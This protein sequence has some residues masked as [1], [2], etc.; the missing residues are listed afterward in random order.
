MSRFIIDRRKLLRNGVPAGV[1]AALTVACGKITED[2]SAFLL[3][4]SDD[5]E[6]PMKESRTGVLSPETFTVLASLSDYV[7]TNWSLGADMEIY[8]TQLQADLDLKTLIAP[9]YLTE[10]ENAAEL[11][12]RVNRHT[13]NTDE[14][15]ALL[16]FSTFNV[17][18]FSFTKLGRA[19]RFVFSEM[20]K[21]QIPISGAFKSFGL[22]NYRGYFGGSYL[23]PDSYRRGER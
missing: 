1:I 16:L 15:W 20:I 14:T 21:H 5:S 7:N 10:Y 13:S 6:R 9:S 11:I 8:H 2:V 12:E 4:F 22:T 19:R 17:E 18:G 23:S 3:I